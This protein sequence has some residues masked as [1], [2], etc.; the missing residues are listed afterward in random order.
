MREQMKK[1]QKEDAASIAKV[2]ATTKRCPGC[3][4]P[5]EKNDGCSHMTCKCAPFYDDQRILPLRFLSLQV[6]AA[7]GH[8]LIK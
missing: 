1:R 7:T 6:E 3:Q 5:I 4:W 2:N 8:S